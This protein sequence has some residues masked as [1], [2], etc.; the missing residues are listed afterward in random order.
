VREIARILCPLDL[1]DVSRHAIDHALLL[2]RWYDAKITVLHSCNPVVIP[3]ADFAVVRLP[4]NME[5]IVE[6]RVRV[7][8]CL[9]SAGASDAAV[10]VESGEPVDRILEYART[11]PADLLVIGTHGAGGFEQHDRQALEIGRHHQHRRSIEKARHRLHVDRSEE[12]D[13]LA[14]PK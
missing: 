7:A 12:L 10:I 1:S 8:E 6:T 11:L 9:V 14:Q 3:S 2:A 4:P 13:P 5:D